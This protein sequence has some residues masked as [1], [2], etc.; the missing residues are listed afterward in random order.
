MVFIL[1]LF[2]WQSKFL[3][4]ILIVKYSIYSNTKSVKKKSLRTGPKK[5]EKRHRKRKKFRRKKKKTKNSNSSFSRLF[6]FVIR[7]K[8]SKPME[9]PSN[10]QRDYIGIPP[11][12]RFI[13]IIDPL[14]LPDRVTPIV[15][16]SPIHKLVFISFNNNYPLPPM[17]VVN[18]NVLQQENQNTAFQTNYEENDIGNPTQQMEM[19]DADKTV[20]QY[21]DQSDCNVAA[22]LQ[23][24]LNKENE[25]KK[26]KTLITPQLQAP[27]T[28][29]KYG[30]LKRKSPTKK[31]VRGMPSLVKGVST[32]QLFPDLSSEVEHQKKIKMP[33]SPIPQVTPSTN[34][35]NEKLSPLRR[36]SDEKETQPEIITNIN[37]ETTPFNGDALDKQIT[38]VKKQ[39]VSTPLT[40]TKSM[41]FLKD[42]AIK[43]KEKVEI[44]DNDYPITDYKSDGSEEDDQ[45]KRRSDK[46]NQRQKWVEHGNLTPIMN[47]NARVDPV[48][49]FGVSPLSA[50]SLMRFVPKEQRVKADSRNKSLAWDD[51]K[52]IKKH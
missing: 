25:E 12:S 3:T 22:E 47:Q 18:S 45:D 16:Q 23:K 24:S 9:G 15:I 32:E 27:K 19:D 29:K 44:Q 42:L 31:L 46:T 51:S 5:S 41:H 40:Q 2:F 1:I 4:Y 26:P 39:H 6:S 36:K 7:N 48:N 34:T 35:K 28:K 13:T 50:I 10:F 8:K 33:I 52:F 14:S 49:V 30:N 43:E 37:T 20:L 38:K 11:E 21:D 17:D